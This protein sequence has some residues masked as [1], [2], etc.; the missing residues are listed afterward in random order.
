MDKD[1]ERRR[2]EHCHAMANATYAIADWCED[3]D[4]LATYL[5]LAAKW[6]RMAAT[7]GEASEP[8]ARRAA[9]G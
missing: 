3:P 9:G 7:P 2:I 1:L 5:E 6:L 8:G 4:M